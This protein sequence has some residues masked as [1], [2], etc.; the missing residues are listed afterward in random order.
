MSFDEFSASSLSRTSLG[1]FT[2]AK[3]KHRTY[4][5]TNNI[6]LSF[7]YTLEKSETQIET[8]SYNTFIANLQRKHY[9]IEGITSSK[10]KGVENY[11]SP[12]SSK[13]TPKKVKHRVRELYEI[14][15]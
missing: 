9:Y 13:S 12:K 5:D 11:P 4:Q 6:S 2:L 1:V 14:I 7:G 10:D 3:S 8:L 15:G